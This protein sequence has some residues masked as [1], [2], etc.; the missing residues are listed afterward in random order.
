MKCSAYW[1]S[2]A[3]RDAFYDLLFWLLIA[4]VVILTI[5]SI[6]LRYRAKR[7][8]KVISDTADARGVRTIMK[9]NSK[10]GEVDTS[11][12]SSNGALVKGHSHF[13]GTSRK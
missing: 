7:R 5:F 4:T 2:C 11:T 12:Y 9:R 1:E 3:D 10:T 8:W 6:W 13:P